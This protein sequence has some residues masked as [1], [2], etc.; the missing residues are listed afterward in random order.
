MLLSAG[1]SMGRLRLHEAM[2]IAR[3]A[4]LTA[5]WQNPAISLAEVFLGKLAPAISARQANF[6]DFVADGTEPNPP[7][8]EGNV[9]PIL[10]L[11]FRALDMRAGLLKLLQLRQI[12]LIELLRLV[13]GRCPPTQRHCCTTTPLPETTAPR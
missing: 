2:D 12:V 8:A 4:I 5:S 9:W 11:P 7:L 6:E 1:S 13:D 3:L 10:L